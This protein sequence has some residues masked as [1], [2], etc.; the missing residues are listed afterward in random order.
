MRI[1]SGVALLV[2][3]ALIL[4]HALSGEGPRR[5]ARP[6]RPRTAYWLFLGITTVNPTTVVYFAAF[7]LGNRELV[8]SPAE[9]VVFVGA[10]FI[11]S[12]LWQL[13]LAGTG[14]ALGRTVTGRLGRRVTGV[15]SALVIAL[16]AVQMVTA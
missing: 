13:L 4:L 12:A 7:V 14:A 8:S 10:A 2:I 6:L 3:A 5:E 9:G 1:L 15:T 16:L 11:A